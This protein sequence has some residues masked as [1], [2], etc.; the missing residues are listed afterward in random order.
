MTKA[1]RTKQ[2]IIETA[3]PIFNKK[4]VA[5]TTIDDVLKATKMAKGGLYGHFTNKEELSQEV[6]SHLL[7]KLRSKAKQLIDNQNSA[8]DK[9][10]AFLSIFE[11]PQQA[12]SEGGC[13]ML[14]FGSEADDTDE[15]IKKQVK[16]SI[17]STLKMLEAI[18]ITGIENH[19]FKETFNAEAFAIK[20]FTM[21]EGNIL[22]ARVLG[23]NRYAKL[24][25]EMLKNE[26]EENCK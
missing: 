6:V 17:Q 4:G 12:L 10:F 11:N 22:V 18:I 7:Y 25:I 15:Q 16:T 5:G 2:F 21:V 20:A 19:E 23:T 14:N 13:P 9:L 3:S 26:I 1:E 8:K 24:C